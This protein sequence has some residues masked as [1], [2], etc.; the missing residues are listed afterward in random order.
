MNQEYMSQAFGR[1]NEIVDRAGEELSQEFMPRAEVC[2]KKKTMD[3]FDGCVSGLTKVHQTST[4]E[5]SMR[6][7]FIANTFTLCL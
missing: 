5:F 7:Q 6:G 3:E 2:Y 1:L 4:R